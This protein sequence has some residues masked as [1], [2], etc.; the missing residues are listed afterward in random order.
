MPLEIPEVPGRRPP[1]PG[2]APRQ[3][4][5]RRDADPRDP[6]PAVTTLPSSRWYGVYPALVRENVDPEGLGRIKVRLPWSPDAGGVGGIPKGQHYEAWARL[7]T[8]AAGRRRGSWFL[9]ET[10]D[11]VLVAFEAGHPA[12]PVV[13]GALWNGQDVPPV[14]ADDDNTIKTIKTRSGSE[15]RFDDQAGGETVEVRTAAGQSVRLATAGGGSLL[16]TDGNANA[17]TLAPSGVTVQASAT[18]RITGSVIT[19]EAAAINL[20]SGLV[21]CDGTLQS[22]TLITESVV[23][24]SYTPGAGNIW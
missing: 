8:M 20:K 17:I 2:R 3:A 5:D 13:V 4:L 9:P 14:T 21:T 16:V 19:L 7:A 11:E 6:R 22:H 15:I 18:V 1:E 23:A 12:R 10:D 24:S